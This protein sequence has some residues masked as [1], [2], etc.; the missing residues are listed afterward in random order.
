MSHCLSPHSRQEVIEGKWSDLLGALEA[1]KSTL[2][3][4]H[5]LMSVFAEIDDCLANMAQIEVLFYK[6]A[7]NYA[8]QLHMSITAAHSRVQYRFKCTCT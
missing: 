6:H 7:H 1:C 4:Y 5:D 8:L 3:R 2:S